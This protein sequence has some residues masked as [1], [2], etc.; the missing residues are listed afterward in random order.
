MTVGMGMPLLWHRRQAM[1]IAGQLPENIED[2]R[3]ILEAASELVETYLSKSGTEPALKI[4]NNVLPF[5]L[6]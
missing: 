2:A 1:V 6:T 4:A 3:L 5:G